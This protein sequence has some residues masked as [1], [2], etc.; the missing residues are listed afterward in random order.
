MGQKPTQNMIAAPLEKPD[1]VPAHSG[2]TARYT[3]N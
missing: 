1:P 2:S 3:G